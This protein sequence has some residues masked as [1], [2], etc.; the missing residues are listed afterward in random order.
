MCHR[1][2]PNLI[3]HCLLGYRSGTRHHDLSPGPFATISK[4]AALLLLLTFTVYSQHSYRVTLSK[5]HLV[6]SILCSK[7]FCGFLSF[8]KNIQ[9]PYHACWTSTLHD[10]ALFSF[11][12]FICSFVLLHSFPS[13]PT[14]FP[15]V[16]STHK[17]CSCLR[18]FALDSLPNA[19]L[20]ERPSL[21][22]LK[23]HSSTPATLCPLSYLTFLHRTY[24]HLTYYIIIYYLC[25]PKRRAWTL[26]YLLLCSQYQTSSKISINIC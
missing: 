7:S 16:P 6:M 22:Y 21:A 25:L 14:A 9:S 2:I 23:C 10:L 26:T 8:L 15:A 4:L 24:H 12:A 17:A 13:S 19:T 3:S 5:H 20:S 18:I 1:N 11:Y